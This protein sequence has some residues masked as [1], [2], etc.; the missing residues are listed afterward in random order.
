MQTLVARD[1]LVGEGEAGHETALLQPE[2]RRERAREEDAL[3][4]GERYHTLA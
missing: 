2:Y 3:D 1:K 4:S